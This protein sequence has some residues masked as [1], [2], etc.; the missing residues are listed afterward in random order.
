L[1]DPPLGLVTSNLFI[2]GPPWVKA[3]PAPPPNVHYHGT[4]VFR[5]RK[6]L[7]LNR[8]SIWRILRAE[9]LDRL[10]DLP[11]LHPDERRRRKG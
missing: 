10:S 8:H 5:E 6:V 2:V 7:R 9:G 11:S 3:P 4:C 1:P